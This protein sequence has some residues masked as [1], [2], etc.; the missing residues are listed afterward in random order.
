MKSSLHIPFVSV[1]TLLCSTLLSSPVFAQIQKNLWEN[2]VFQKRL[3]GSF[4]F[5][6]E[7]EPSLSDTEQADY[8]QIRPL[9][10]DAPDKALDLL[11]QLSKLPDA[12]ARF[13]FLIA[14]LDRKSVV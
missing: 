5:N 3:Q 12:S 7:I 8:E 1:V 2:P 6:S 13:D 4:G 14:N 9:L 10:Q 11:T